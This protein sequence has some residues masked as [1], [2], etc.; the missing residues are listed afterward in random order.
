[1]DK[2]RLLALIVAAIAVLSFILGNTLSYFSDIEVS[3]GNVFQAGVWSQASNCELNVDGAKINCSSTKLHNIS[4]KN[5]GI[6]DLTITKL[7]LSW[8]GGGNV[9]K[10]KVGD[11]QFST[12][13]ASPVIIN[14]DI[15]IE[16]TD[17]GDHVTVWLEDFTFEGNEFTLITFFSDDSQ[18]EDSFIPDQGGN[19]G[20]DGNS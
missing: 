6:E 10:I 5:T 13:Q 2:T 20:K 18:K 19:N 15:I 1:M 11:Q 7:V 16:D 14:E 12:S 17:K 8:D 3:S 9:T 4:I